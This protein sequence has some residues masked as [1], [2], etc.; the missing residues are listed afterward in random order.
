[1]L[2]RSS[3]GFRVTRVSSVF[4]IVRVAEISNIR[5]ERISKT[6]HFLQFFVKWNSAQQ[7]HT[8]MLKAMI[9]EG[10]YEIKKDQ[11]NSFGPTKT[12]YFFFMRR[13]EQAP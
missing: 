7:K 1:M 6:L 4:N 11:T 3:G 8:E 12:Q 5:C 13:N 2:Y 10:G 9:V